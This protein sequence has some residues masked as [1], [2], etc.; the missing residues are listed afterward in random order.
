M[1][2]WRS[3]IGHHREMTPC[4]WLCHQHKNEFLW[5]CS[6]T[7]TVDVYENKTGSKLDPCGTPLFNVIG[8]SYSFFL[9]H[10]RIYLISNVLL[11]SKIILWL[12]SQ[13]HE[14]TYMQYLYR[15][16]QEENFIS[17]NHTHFSDYRTQWGELM[18]KRL[19]LWV[20]TLSFVTGK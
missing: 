10:F 3:F 14:Y 20:R 2:V 11:T 7:F 16:P 13:E 18:Q 19:C 15:V 8:G 1:I 4:K 17:C 6:V 12:Q 9:L 5:V